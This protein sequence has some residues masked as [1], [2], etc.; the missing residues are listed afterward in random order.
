MLPKKASIY[1]VDLPAFTGGAC[2]G[3]YGI[4]LH[5]LLFLDMPIEKAKM[6]GHYVK[7]TPAARAYGL[8]G[9]AHLKTVKRIKEEYV[10]KRG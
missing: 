7:D 10:T 9:F 4:L 3:D 2:S 1:T 6:Q 5:I 8:T